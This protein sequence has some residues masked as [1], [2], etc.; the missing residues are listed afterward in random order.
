MSLNR[1]S[2][3]VIVCGIVA[4]A[5]LSALPGSASAQE[6]RPLPREVLV[7]VTEIPPLYVKTADGRWEG[8]GAELWDAVARHAGLA[9]QYK[10]YG[11]LGAVLDALGK[12]EIDVIPSLPAEEKLEVSMD[13]S[14]SYLKSGLA[15]AVPAEGA[16]SRWLGVLEH[17]F[18]KDVLGALVLLIA[19]S[20]LAGIAVWFLERRRNAEM[21]DHR[22]ARGIGDGIWWSVVTMTT[23]GYGDKAPR[24][25]GGRVVAFVWMLLSIVFIAGFTANITASLT[26]TELRGKVRGF[27]DLYHARIG[28]LPRSEAASHLAKHG[29]AFM[30]FDNV[31]DGMAA[32]A[33]G[34][35][36]AFVLNELVLKHLAKDKYPGRVQ[37]LPGVFDEY[38]V[39]IALQERS[40]LRKPINRALLKFM[41]SDGWSALMSRYSP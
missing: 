26:V 12:G 16:G 9:Y 1:S 34:R 31:E 24:T 5:L 27:S 41:R 14:Q 6:V 35:I 20:T 33:D 10:E 21:F 30:S 3:A 13:F 2:A 4:I 15:I 32:L 28:S 18:S 11:T 29:I 23:V 17:L 40:P 19:M 37:V 39:S 38:F 8:L 36:D 7:G 22:P 25:I